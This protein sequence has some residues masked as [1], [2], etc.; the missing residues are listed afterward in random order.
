MAVWFSRASA[1]LVAAPARR[2]RQGTAADTIEARQYIVRDED[3]YARIT[4]A[5]NPDGDARIRINGSHGGPKLAIGEKGGHPLLLMFDG[6]DA[7]R[8]VDEAESDALVASAPLRLWVGTGE[9]RLPFLGMYD[10]TET[11]VWSAP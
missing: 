1:W 3:G 7:L 8:S 11:V 6:P 5:V 10:E 4:L 9:D 2:S